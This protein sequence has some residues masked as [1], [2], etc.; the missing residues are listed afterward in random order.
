MTAEGTISVVIPV[1][2]GELYLAE[3]IDS[4]LAQ[5]PAPVEVIVVDD[6]STDGSAAVAASYAERGVRTACLPGRGIGAARN[7]GVE[8]AGG[9]LLAFLDADDVWEPGKLA[10]QLDCMRRDP[11]PD[12]VFGHIVQFRSPDLNPAQASRIVCPPEPR[13]APVSST[14][15]VTRTAFE[16]VGGFPTG[17]LVGET[18]EWVMRARDAGLREAMVDQVL[19]RRRLHLTNNSLLHREHVSAHA[20]ILK[21]A[22]ERR[23]A[24]GRVA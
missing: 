6:G 9:A 17:T 23:R 21:A 10:T 18:M 7:L 1:R 11:Y 24:A 19:S 20:S 15:L 5:A 4:A 2:D 13:P 12:I 8:L 22:L 16:R 3:A 14:M